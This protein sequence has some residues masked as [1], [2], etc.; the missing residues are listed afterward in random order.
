MKEILLTKEMVAFVDNRDYDWLMKM[1]RWKFNPTGHATRNAYHNGLYSVVSMHRVVI[2]A[3]LDEYS[4]IPIPYV[5]GHVNGDRLDNQINNLIIMDDSLHRH[6]KYGKQ[7]GAWKQKLALHYRPGISFLRHRHPH[8]GTFDNEQVVII[9]LQ[10]GSEA[11]VDPVD[12][13]LVNAYTWNLSGHGY[14][15]TTHKIKGK[16]KELFLHRLIV[17]SYPETFD[18]LHLQVDHINRNR[19]DN[20]KCNLRLVTAT[21]NMHNRV[22]ERSNTGYIGVAK[23]TEGMTYQSWAYIGGRNIYLGCFHDPVEAAKVHDRFILAHMGDY[24]VLNFPK[25]EE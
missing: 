8:L 21:Q 18:N 5:V 7:D 17:D 25:E 24:A 12:F 19:L 4:N 6:L 3:H 20:R 14:V 11:I 9:P 1:G 22:L 16:R 10:E 13:E 2:Q 23:S 15:R